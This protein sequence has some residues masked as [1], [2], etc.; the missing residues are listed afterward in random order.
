[1]DRVT[2]PVAHGPLDHDAL[3]HDPIY[4][5]HNATTPLLPEVFD[6]MVPY[7]RERFGNPSSA[8]VYGTRAARA[9]AVAR[10][11]VATLLG[12]D[13]DEV[14]FTSGGTEANNLAIRGAAALARRQ[15]IVTTVI[16]HP[17]TA[18]PCGWLEAHGCRV[19]RIGVEPDGQAS[20]ADAR[21]MILAMGVAPQDAL[22]L[23]APHPRARHHGRRHRPGRRGAHSFVAPAEGSV[24]G[25]RGD[26][27]MWVSAPSG[28]H[29]IPPDLDV[30]ARGRVDTM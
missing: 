27:V 22:G 4:L 16:E 23:G 18:G 20:L 9:V 15:H 13:P 17:A 5:D 6:A 28:G 2:H 11:R 3:S 24:E 14:I 25:G 7:L 30:L 26:V 1:V 29:T 10:E 12:C 21:A 8:H 19:S